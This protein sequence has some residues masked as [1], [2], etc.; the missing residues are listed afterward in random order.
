MRY[1]TCSCGKA[2]YF[3]SGMFPQ[4]CEGC[5]ECGTNFNKEPLEP[6]DWR[7]VYDQYT[8]KQNARECRKC[9]HYEKTGGDTDGKGS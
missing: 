7:V 6:H 5:E 4:P 3:G 8:G 1:Y 9:H 2:E